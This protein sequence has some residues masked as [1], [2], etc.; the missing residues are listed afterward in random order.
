MKRIGRAAVWVAGF[1]LAVASP[2]I[3]QMGGRGGPSFR[4]DWRPTVRA[5]TIYRSEEGGQPAMTWEVAC[6]GQEGNGYWVETRFTSGEETISKALTAPAGVQRIIVKAGR[7]PAMELPVFAAGA[8]APQTDL[9]ETGRIIGKETIT[10]PAGAF[11]CDHYQVADGGKTVDAWVSE[12]VSP[13]G[14]V[15]VAGPGMTMTLQKLVTG[16][17]SRITETPQKVEI[18]SMPGLMGEERR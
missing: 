18:P 12:R 14:I 13:Y 5:E 3:A 9:K 4:G 2:S 7:E 15:K 1:T 17:K 6:V 10:T 16:A 8:Q 11:E